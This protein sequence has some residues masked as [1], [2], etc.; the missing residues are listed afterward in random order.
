[1]KSKEKEIKETISDRHRNI[2]EKG[3]LFQELR[4]IL[5]E[6][7]MSDKESDIFC[8]KFIKV[9]ENLLRNVDLDSCEKLI[10]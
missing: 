6:N 2:I 1:M 10:F 4:K 3:S 7:N 9:Y 8:S 5:I